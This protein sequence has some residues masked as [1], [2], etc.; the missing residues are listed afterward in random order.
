MEESF[1]DRLMNPQYEIIEGVKYMAPSG[2][3]E[4][5]TA[6]GNLYGIFWDYLWNNNCGRVFHDSLDVHFPDGNVFQP[7]LKIVLDPSIIKRRG[8][9]YGVP[10]LCAEVLSKSTAKKD[11]GIKKD[12][13][14]RN[15][16]REYWIIN[17]TDKS[18]T[19][20]HLLEGKYV[21]DDVYSVYN[22]VEWENLTDEE[23][24]AAK[25]KIKVTLFDDL[26]VDVHDVFRW[27][28]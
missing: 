7:D 12:V 21:L 15:G 4:H 25:F 19:V 24:A 9:I 11:I 27:I 23:R 17:P 8:V 10:D 16:V 2:S 1:N 26:E 14:E 28:D 18:I 3:G 5:S 6:I 13:Y 22:P 20:Y